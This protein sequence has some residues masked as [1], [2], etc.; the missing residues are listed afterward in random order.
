MVA[1]TFLGGAVA[2]RLEAT[3]VILALSPQGV[4]VALG[5]RNEQVYQA[6]EDGILPVYKSGIKSRVLIADVEAWVRSWPVRKYKPRK[7]VPN[8]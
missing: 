1:P 6:I 5:I 8:G 7:V 2:A 4:A 3:V